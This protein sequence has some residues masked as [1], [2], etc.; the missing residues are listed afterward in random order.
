MI[1]KKICMLGTSSVGKTSLVERFVSDSFSDRYL[2]TVGVKLSKKTV[3][4]GDKTVQLVLWDLNGE[5]RFQR[6][7][8]SFLRGSAAYFLV[9]DGTR[10]ETE[11]TALALQQR[12][13]AALGDVPFIVLLNKADLT[14][15]W[16]VS[17]DSIRR[18][19][20]NGWRCIRTSAKTAE[21]VE[22]AFEEIAKLATS[23]DE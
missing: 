10:S 12:A 16:D 21:G 11:S 15:E 20:N 9:I 8:T 23:S 22:Y 2:T 19:E 17:E 14:S 4:I 3:E 5:D 7:S 18:F 13:A 6:V 1:Q